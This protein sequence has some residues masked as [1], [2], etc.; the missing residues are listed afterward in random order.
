MV[1]RRKDTLQINVSMAAN[2]ADA[3]EFGAKMGSPASDAERCI[4]NVL[5]NPRRLFHV[6]TLPIRPSGAPDRME[7]IGQN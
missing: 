5:K 2:S 4:S 6:M 3:L 7:V 1:A